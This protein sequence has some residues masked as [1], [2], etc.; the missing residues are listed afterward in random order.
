[1]VL[2][3]SYYHPELPHAR[4][5]IQSEFNPDK[6]RQLLDRIGLNASDG[7]GIREMNA[8]PFMGIV[9][10]RLGRTVGRMAGSHSP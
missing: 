8:K 2:P 10:E 9:L 4:H 1:M 3:P 6:A 7:D 5:D